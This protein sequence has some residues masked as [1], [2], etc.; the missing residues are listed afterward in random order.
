MKFNLFKKKSGPVSVHG[1]AAS[2]A[3]KDYYKLVP[4]STTWGFIRNWAEKELI[5]HRTEND[6]LGLDEKATAAIRG[7]IAEL[8]DILALPGKKGLLADTSQID[9]TRSEYG[10]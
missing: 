8:R 5:R 6:S 9:H 10:E 7:R 2:E 1:D 3:S 4:S